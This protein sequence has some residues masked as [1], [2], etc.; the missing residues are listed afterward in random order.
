MD[1][2]PPRTP[3]PVPAHFDALADH[4]HDK[5]CAGCPGRMTLKPW[6]ELYVMWR[7]DTCSSFELVALVPR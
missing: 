3:D 5:A 1:S 4:P 7:C 6:I 2:T